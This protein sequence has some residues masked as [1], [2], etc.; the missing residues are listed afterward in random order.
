MPSAGEQ[1][2]HAEARRADRRLGDLGALEFLAVRGFLLRRERRWRV[3]ELA[4]RA[5]RVRPPVCAR[6]GRWHRALPGMPSPAGRACPGTA[7]PGRGTGTRPCPRHRLGLR[8][9]VDAARVGERLA[10]LRQ[11][12]RK[13]RVELL[14]QVVERGRRPRRASAGRRRSRLDCQTRGGEVGEFGRGAGGQRIAAPLRRSRQCAAVS[15]RRQTNSS[16]GQRRSAA[17]GPVQV[18]AGVLFEHRVEVGAAEAEG[19]DAGGARILGAV[20]PRPR[21]GVQVE[22]AAVEVRLRVGRL[23]QRRRQHLVMQR[24]R[25]S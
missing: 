25:A 7:I 17:L 10:R 14:L 3:D 8:G 1:A 22:R 23:D 12:P 19:A 4:E 20:D 2:E 21:L 18:I 24:E 5:S 9:E 16:A 11:S 6:P 13:C 15:G